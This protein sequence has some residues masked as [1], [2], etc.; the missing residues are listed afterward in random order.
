M[1]RKLKII[2][3]EP[4]KSFHFDRLSRPVQDALKSAPAKALNIMNKKKSSLGPIHNG[5]M[6]PYNV[7]TYSNNYLKRAIV[8]LVGIGANI[9]EDAIYP[10]MIDKSLNG[11]AYK[12]KIHFDSYPNI[13][14]IPPVNAFWS[15]TLYDESG[16]AIPNILDRYTLSSWMPLKYN[17]DGSLDLYIQ[18]KDPSL[19][20]SGLPRSN[21]LPAPNGSFTLTMRLYWPSDRILDGRWI[22]PPIALRIN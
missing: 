14:S 22:P 17:R 18:N 2:R 8:A 21:W 6:I 9:N 1:I 12:Y 15:I 16:F 3:F 4:G 19:E 11:K 10:L 7:G 13:T 20:N 5:W